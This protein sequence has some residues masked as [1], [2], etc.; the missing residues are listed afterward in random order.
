[1]KLYHL[2]RIQ[3]LPIAIEHAWEFFSSPNNLSK[4]TPERMNFKI[5][6]VSGGGTAYAGQIIKYKVNV[7]RGIRVNWITEI[8]HVNKP[9]HFIDNQRFG[10]YS[11]WHHQH[12]F[13]EVPGGVELI[14]EVN[15]ALPLGVL[16]RLAHWIFVRGEVNSIFDHRYNV[17]EKHFSIK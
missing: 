1:M 16:G 2:K 17:L 9:F 6:Y 3:F 8:T 12:M 14:D 13:K 10:P 15:Y 4:I 7:L 5:L 11:F